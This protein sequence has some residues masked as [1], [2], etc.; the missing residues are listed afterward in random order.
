[1]LSCVQLFVTPW[2]VA[3]QAPL[4]LGFPRQEYWSGL[5]FPS[6]GDL[7]EPGIKPEAPALAADS[8]PLSHQGSPC[9]FYVLC[10]QSF[11]CVQLF[12]F[13][14]TVAL[15][16]PLSI[17]FSRQEYRSRMPFPTPG[18]LPDGNLNLPLLHWQADSLP[19]APPVK[20]YHT[21]I[22]L[23]LIPFNIREKR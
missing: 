7:P 11:S 1:M 4:S 15:Q 20:P 12:A 23:L 19:Q 17:E 22:M 18:D 9:M 21:T 8:L 16:A 6:P 10:A 5:P 13:L 2:T 14:W 3:R